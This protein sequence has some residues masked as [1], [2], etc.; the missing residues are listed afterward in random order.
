MALL[1]CVFVFSPT[2]TA[3][4]FEVIFI[5]NSLWLENYLRVTVCEETIYI[6]PQNRAGPLCAQFK[7]S[8]LRPAF[9]GWDLWKQTLR[10]ANVL[11]KC[12][13]ERF[14]G[15]EGQGRG[16]QIPSLCLILWSVLGHQ[17]GLRV[18]PL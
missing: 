2:E 12:S 13:Q 9:L 1:L 14:E 5:L 18:Y 17:L 7:D 11:R 16:W 8:W 3:G 15:Q 10:Q 6:P 4:P